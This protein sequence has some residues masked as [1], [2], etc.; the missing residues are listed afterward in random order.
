MI[1][2]R[3]FWWEEESRGVALLMAARQKWRGYASAF[4]TCMQCH[5]STL[6]VLSAACC[7]EGNITWCFCTR[8]AYCMPFSMQNQM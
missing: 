2:E 5:L 7:T 4:Y 8:L 1:W 6:T 3:A